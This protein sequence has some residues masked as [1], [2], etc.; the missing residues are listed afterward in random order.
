VVVITA[1]LAP[2]LP[3]DT[4]PDYSSI[5]SAP[6][7]GHLLGTDSI[8]RDNLARLLI[9]GRSSLFVAL[10]AVVF[11]LSIGVGLGLAAGYF[12]GKVDL[13]ISAF[14]DVILAFPGVVLLMVLVAVRGASTTTIVVG[15]TVAVTPTFTRIAR[16]NTL[17]FAQRGF[18][19][20]ARVQGARSPRI[21][22][23]ELLPNVL[24]TV[25][26]YAFV[27][28]A[29]AMVAQGSLSFIG[30]GVPPPTPSW[31]GMVADGLPLLDQEPTIALIP[32][33]VLFLTVLS[34]NLIGD[35]LRAGSDK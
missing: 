22:F 5:A 24:P 34:F 10:C 35:S 2:I 19:T 20:A 31:G 33:G 11:G 27:V 26:A 28:A 13:V 18:V 6:S 3:L 30:L 7:T 9:G 12:R 29:V 17:S 8:G 4:N 21:M 1:V 32:A 25:Q 16:A 14:V 23:R 15:L